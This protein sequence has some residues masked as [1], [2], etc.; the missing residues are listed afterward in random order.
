VADGKV[1][2]GYFQFPF[3]SEESVL[4]AEASECAADQEK[5]WEYHDALFLNQSDFSVERLKSLAVET[6]LD[7]KS[8]KECLDSG[9]NKTIVQDQLKFAQQIGVQSTPSFMMNG[10]PITGAQPFE[11]FQ[12]YI[13]QLL[14]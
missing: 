8:F 5:F 6:G 9:K 12:R 2:I 13:E 14:K 7:S 10:V 3:L 4:A 1:R 11:V